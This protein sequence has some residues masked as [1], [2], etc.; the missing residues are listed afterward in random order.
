MFTAQGQWFMFFWDVGGMA[1]WLTRFVSKTQNPKILAKSDMK[2]KVSLDSKIKKTQPKEYWSHD[3]PLG[4]AAC[5]K[6]PFCK[7][8]G[9]CAMHR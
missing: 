8:R 6:L 1:E 3:K 2:P 5:N 9:G 7:K 4:G